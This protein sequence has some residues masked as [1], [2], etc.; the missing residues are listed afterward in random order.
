MFAV[1][2]RVAIGCH[3]L[4]PRSGWQ[5]IP[6]SSLRIFWCIPRQLISHVW[7]LFVPV[8]LSIPLW[9]ALCLIFI[10]SFPR[11]APLHLFQD[12]AIIFTWWVYSLVSKTVEVS[13]LTIYPSLELFILIFLLIDR[14]KHVARSL[15]S[16]GLHCLTR[17]VWFL[18]LLFCCFSVCYSSGRPWEYSFFFRTQF[19]T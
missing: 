18:F 16:L 4:V 13:L 1:S 7:V 17:I 3:L 12:I 9:P 5:L 10:F 2:A 14:V 19:L 6:E 8:S 11:S 15:G